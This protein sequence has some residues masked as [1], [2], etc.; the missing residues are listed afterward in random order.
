VS[1][2]ITVPA[3][4]VGESD[5]R[6]RIYLALEGQAPAPITEAPVGATTQLLVTVEL[7]QGRNDFTATTISSGGESEASPVVTYILDQDAPTISITSPKSGS[8]VSGSTVKLEGKVQARSR[9]VARN[10]SNGSSTT[11]SAGDDQK[12]SLTLS[13]QSGTNKIL[14]TATDP[15][16]NVGELSMSVVRGSG[17]LSATLAASSYRISVGSLPTSIQ[18]VATVT[19]PAGNPLSGASVTFSLT[20]PKIPAITFE[21]TTGADGRAVFTT[22]I[23]QGVDPGS[24]LASILI[25]AEGQGQTTAQVAITVVK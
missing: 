21:A 10:E 13:L 17:R 6:V 4:M 25:M 18:L 12:F 24:G 1:L 20:L 22:T 14:I 15:A 9:L 8:A 7:T 2:Q 3:S 19:D 11:G 23:P 16:G 5:G